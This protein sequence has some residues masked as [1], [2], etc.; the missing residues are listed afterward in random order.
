MPIT[1]YLERNAKEWP[2]DVALVELNPSV[3]LPKLTTWREYELIEPARTDK[4][5]EE[6]T[7]KVFDEKA[8][9]VANYLIT[10]GIR[11]GEKV[12]ILLMNCLSWLPIY[13]GILKAGAVA[14]PLN[15]RYAADEIE[16][17]VNLADIR[18]LIF[19]DEFIGR[20]EEIVPNIGPGRLLLYFGQS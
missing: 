10:R 20:V 16:Y 15:F 1:Q 18:V 19:G 14:V 17:C 6:I 13:F 3:S 2:D 7:W 11:P 8:N 5:R 9:R 12:G 4:Y